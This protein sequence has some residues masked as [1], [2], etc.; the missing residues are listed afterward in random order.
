MQQEIRLATFNVRNLVLPGV[1]Y[2]DDL[3]A[4]TREEYQ[5]KTAW[6]AERIDQSDA[7]IIG[8]Q[9]IFSRK[10]LSD[11]MA[12]TRLYRD[13]TLI[14]F[15]RN[16]PPVI[17]RPQVA[18]L[19]RLPLAG[20]PRSHITFPEKFKITLP[21]TDTVINQ[22]S[23]PVL[24]VP[25]LLPGGQPLNIYVVHLKS[26]RPDF[27]NL[28]GKPDP[29]QYGLAALRSLMRRAADA[30]GIRTLVSEFR[31]ENALPVAILGD[32]NDFSQA[33]STCI[34]T[35][36]THESEPPLPPFYRLYDC[37]DIQT[38]PEAPVEEIARFME[39]NG[40]PRID[41]ILVSEEFTEASGYL[42]GRIKTMTYQQNEGNPCNPELSDHNLALATI[43]LCQNRL[44][45]ASLLHFH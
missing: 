13:A 44:V 9:E 40:T 34:V 33:V 5:A 45:P 29:Y 36:E 35:G 42:A 3:P 14:C 8:F 20:S 18:L 30:L 19:S 23:R 27:I 11:V 12:K 41:H 4:Y 7:D 22:F 10:A 2:Y 25:I 31:K 21:I 26:K 1:T 43:T 17:L 6:I 15:D 39:A 32:F 24:E 16:N 38:E 37:F 28:P